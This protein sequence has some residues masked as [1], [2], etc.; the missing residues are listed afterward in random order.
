MGTGIATGQAAGIT[1]VFSLIY[2]ISPAEI[3][4]GKDQ[5]ILA[6]LNKYLRSQ[7]MVF[8]K[9]E[10]FDEE[11]AHWAYP[12]VR[13]LLALGLLAGGMDNDFQYD[14]TATQQ[15]FIILLLNGIYRLDK[16]KYSLQLDAL[17]RPYIRKEALTKQKAAEIL[18][19]LYGGRKPE[20]PSYEEACEKGYINEV[21]QLRLKDRDILNLDDVYYLACSSIKAHVK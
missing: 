11:N 20:S 9:S 17:L 19:T 1:A 14:K 16:E 13:E 18:L 15:D 21:L 3:E 5:N 2:N 8:E 12:A 4:K 7:G 6:E 10:P